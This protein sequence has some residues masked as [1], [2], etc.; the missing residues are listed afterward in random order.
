[1]RISTTPQL[2]RQFTPVVV[3]AGLYVKRDDLFS[4][5]SS[6]PI[7][8][9]KLRQ[10]L[11]MLE[12]MVVARLIS[13][14]SIHSPQPAIV[15]YVA[16]YLGVPS[17][18][19]V[20]GK[21]ETVSLTLARSF[22]ADIVR[23]P[24]GRHTVLFAKARE[25]GRAGDFIVPFGMRPETPDRLFYEVCGA[26]VSN[27]PSHIQRIVIASGSGVTAT[28]VAYG[29]SRERRIR[30]RIT[31]IN[32][33]PDRRRQ[34]LQ[35]LQTLDP[36]SAKWVKREIVLEA[37]TPSQHHQFRYESPVQF[38]FGNIALHPLYE[39]KA[40]SWFTNHV[41]FDSSNTLFWVTGP[42]LDLTSLGESS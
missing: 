26:Q 40:F 18:I 17:T 39:A 10:C 1:M 16:R 38:Q 28:A 14:A 30:P 24:S 36:A 12:D 7:R 8:G 21:Q 15:A 23:C 41:D 9:G 19:F 2:I 4:I 37:L 3:E 27:V 29:L 32:L 33:G 6:A 31:M 42:P 5:E 34:L 35:T 22:G 13:A 20:G 25:L 11:L